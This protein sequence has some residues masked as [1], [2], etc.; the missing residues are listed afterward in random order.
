[1]STVSSREVWGG[2]VGEEEEREGRRNLGEGREVGGIWGRGGKG[3]NLGEGRN[4]GEF[5]GGEG[6]ARRRYQAMLLFFKATY[7]IL[8][9]MCA[10][11]GFQQEEEID[12]FGLYVDLGESKWMLV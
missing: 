1:M 8:K 7:D 6:E 4:G 12:E 9:E 2:K 10:L 11:L 5:W 3:S